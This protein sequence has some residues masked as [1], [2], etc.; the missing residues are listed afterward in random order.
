MPK[1]TITWLAATAGLLLLIAVPLG[2]SGETEGDPTTAQQISNVL[3]P[4]A[5]LCILALLIVLAVSAF[6]AGRR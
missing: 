1:R 6:R 5:V 3:F 2:S 4:L